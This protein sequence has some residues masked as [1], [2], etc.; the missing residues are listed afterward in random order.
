MGAAD[1]PSERLPIFTPTTE[2]RRLTRALSQV[3]H[4]TAEGVWTNFSN[5]APQ[6]RHPYS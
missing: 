3:G 5:S 1:A 4:A 6:A 2:R